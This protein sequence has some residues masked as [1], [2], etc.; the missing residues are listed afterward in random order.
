MP[1]ISNGRNENNVWLWKHPPKSREACK[2][3]QPKGSFGDIT[4]HTSSQITTHQR[5]IIH[6]PTITIPSTN[7]IIPHPKLMSTSESGSIHTRPSTTDG[8]KRGER[9]IITMAMEAT[10]LLDLE[11]DDDSSSCSSFTVATVL[12]RTKD[13]T[14]I[15]RSQ[16]SRCGD[17]F[18]D[19]TSDR[20]SITIIDKDEELKKLRCTSS[21]IDESFDSTADDD[22]VFSSPMAALT[23]QEQPEP[24]ATVNNLQ[25]TVKKSNCRNAT[26]NADQ[27]KGSNNRESIFRKPIASDKPVSFLNDST[28]ELQAPT[29][30]PLQAPYDETS[31]NS[32]D[33][34]VGSLLDDT[35]ESFDELDREAF[36]RRRSNRFLSVYDDLSAQAI[37]RSATFHSTLASKKQNNNKVK[38]MSVAFTTAVQSVADEISSHAVA[39]AHCDVGGAWD[40]TDLQMSGKKRPLAEISGLQNLRKSW[41]G[42]SSYIQ[43]QL[44]AEREEERKMY[45]QVRSMRLETRDAHCTITNQ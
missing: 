36:K 45:N 25:K 30:T 12:S 44:L 34:S 32:F 11:D 42:S 31:N 6:P 10:S 38:R 40:V 28:P 7:I 21:L 2:R 4:S 20:Q 24:N 26:S 14:S 29:K 5:N 37:Q 27:P 8:Q 16:N 41:V 39:N 35:Y 23:A 3:Y 15:A 17:S 19:M 33:A 22:P 43:M 9:E 13:A 18:N 1:Q